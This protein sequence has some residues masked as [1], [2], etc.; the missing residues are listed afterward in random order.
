M[1]LSGLSTVISVL[2]MV[3]ERRTRQGAERVVPQTILLVED[4]ESILTCLAEFL[5]R[6]LSVEVLQARTGRE[7]IVH[8]RVTK[9]DL[10]VVDLGLP[11]MPGT[12]VIR[13]LRTGAHLHSATNP[14]IPVVIISGLQVDTKALLAVTSATQYIQKPIDLPSTMTAVQA[15]L[16]HSQN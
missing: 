2:Q 16:R 10:L 9:V 7:A 12:D 1:I 14:K 8:L 3:R 5:G 6:S 4:E 13:V 15:A 11:D